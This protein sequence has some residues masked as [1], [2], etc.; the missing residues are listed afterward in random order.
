MGEDTWLGAL[1]APEPGARDLEEEKRKGGLVV[2]LG[3][4]RVLC[5]KDRCSVELRATEQQPPGSGGGRGGSLALGAVGAQMG[6][7]N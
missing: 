6:K 3:T 4:P 5:F 7:G 2:A 1:S